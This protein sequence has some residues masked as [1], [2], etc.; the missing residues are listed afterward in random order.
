MYG[1]RVK[2]GRCCLT[3]AGTKHR[4]EACMQG[5]RT[6]CILHI[7]AAHSLWRHV[8]GCALQHTNKKV[9]QTQAKGFVKGL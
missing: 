1:H 4:A 6:L 2:A 7:R 8:R 3:V 5:L 9:R